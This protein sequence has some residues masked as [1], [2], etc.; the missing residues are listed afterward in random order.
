MDQAAEHAG[1]TVRNALVDQGFMDQGVRYC[2]GLDVDIA[3]IERNPQHRLYR[4]P[5]PE[6]SPDERAMRVKTTP[7]SPLTWQPAQRSVLDR[8]PLPVECGI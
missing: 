1:G 8:Q 5:P 3:I 7:D 2:A 4:H 6:E